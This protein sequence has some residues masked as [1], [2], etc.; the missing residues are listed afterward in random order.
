[1]RAFQLFEAG[2]PPALVSLAT[3]VPG[4]GQILVKI[5]ACGL[6]FADLLMIKGSYQ[7]TPEPPFTLGLE[8]AGRIEALGDGV[9][10]LS[11]G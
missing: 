10:G 8:V 9:T 4:L 6:N 11:V 2:Q 5:E 3:P 7:D 1:M